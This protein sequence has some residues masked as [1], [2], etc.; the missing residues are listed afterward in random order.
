[1]QL[2]GFN[3]VTGILHCCVYA[4]A[5]RREVVYVGKTRQPWQR[6]Y[7]HVN[8]RG[9]PKPYRPGM[10]NVKHGIK[11]DQVF[12]RNCM[13]GELDQL[14]LDMIAKY[15]PRHNIKG[16]PTPVPLG[17]EQLIA[18]ILVSQG[19]M[20]PPIAMPRIHRRF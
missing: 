5:S 2:E 18:E 8:A 3:E 9:R 14:E 17:L 16:R 4:L 12:I 19:Q 15:L 7:A 20:P 10:S 1:M 11:F 13:L 6:L